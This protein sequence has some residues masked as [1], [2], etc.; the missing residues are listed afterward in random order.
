M[1]YKPRTLYTARELIEADILDLETDYRCAI[2]DSQPDY[3]ETVLTQ[4][5]RAQQKLKELG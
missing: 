3:A 4:L 1:I 2:R 5:K